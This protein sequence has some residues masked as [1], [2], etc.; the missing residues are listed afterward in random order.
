MVTGAPTATR[1]GQQRMTTS[2]ILTL[3]QWLSGAYPLGSFA[4]SHGLEA[5]IDEGWVHDATTLEIWLREV[6]RE[7]TGRADIIVLRA[8]YQSKTRAE[9]MEIDATARAFAAS[10]ERLRESLHQG[11]AFA[12]TTSAIADIDVPEVLF[13][14]AVGCAAARLDIPVE[15]TAPMYSQAFASSIVMACV[16]LM[17]LGQ[18]QAH[19]VISNLAQV[20]EQMAIETTG[21]TLDDL[22]SNTFLSD[23][24]AMRHEVQP[25]RLFQS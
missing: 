16:R 14:V 21:A 22:Y 9:L 6:L 15:I 12:R 23:I 11:A 5:A 1:M 3:Q 7:G 25:H 17:R 24:A 19:R 13:P 2:A 4:Y 10:H 8:A 20:C 18:T